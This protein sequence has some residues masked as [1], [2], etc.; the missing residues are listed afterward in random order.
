MI[1]DIKAINKND[2]AAG[3]ILFLLYPGFWA[4][5]VHRYISHPL[6]WMGNKIRNPFHKGIFSFFALLFAQLSRFITQIE[7]HPGAKI[8]KGLFI[9]HGNG[10]VIGETA[11]IGDNCVIFHG[12]TIGGTGNHTGKRHPTI[13]NKVF[14]GTGATILGPVTI[15]DNV[16]IGA[17]SVIVMHNVPANATVIGSPARIVKLNGIKTD[18]PL[19]RTDYKKDEKK[20]TM[21]VWKKTYPAYKCCNG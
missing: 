2:P 18:L 20:I 1:E 3:G 8:G 13:G 10:V 17:Q 4:I 5:T 16:K 11:V 21:Q 6:Y 15:A 14:I 19:K 12:V 9:D 7:I